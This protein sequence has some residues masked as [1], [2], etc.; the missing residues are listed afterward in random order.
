MMK[1]RFVNQLKPSETVNDIFLLAEKSLS[2]KK[3]GDS[4]LSMVFADK[5]GKINAV[6]W[7]H[8]EKIKHEIAT[9]NFVR[10]QGSVG[11]YKGSLQII[12]KSIE[13]LSSD[14]VSPEDFIPST[15]R[16]S[17]H[18]LERLINVS[19]TIQSSHFRE[20]LELF[21]QDEEFVKKLKLAPA[22]KKMHHAYLGGLLEHTLSLVLLADKVADHYGGIDKDL[23]LTGAILHDIGKI[24]EFD[25]EHQIDYSVEG[26]LIS[27]IVIGV[28][29]VEKKISRIDNFPKKAALLLKHLIVSHH[30]SRE[31]GSP[32]PPMTLEAVMLNYLDDIDSKMNGIREFMESHDTGE[33]WTPYHRL[34]ERFFYKGK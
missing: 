5:T 15:R 7:D 24:I 13:I 23:L 26:R 32:Q 20:L 14:T 10:V 22:A 4:Y 1:K 17:Q 9:G 31:L 25:Y 8:I 21:W 29:L 16:N 27:H 11:E 34:L 18:M 6:V 3:D 33:E 30:G 12:V 2:L 28:D 19:R